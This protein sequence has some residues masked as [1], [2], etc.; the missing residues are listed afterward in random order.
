MK[1]DRRPWYIYHSGDY[2]A[3]LTATPEIQDA[4]NAYAKKAAAN[5][6]NDPS[7]DSY[8]S[9]ST[10]PGR[11]RDGNWTNWCPPLWF[12]EWLAQLVNGGK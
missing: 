10:Y 9:T 12:P 2:D 7:L 6:N 5:F 11:D 3:Y 4:W 1:T 8:D